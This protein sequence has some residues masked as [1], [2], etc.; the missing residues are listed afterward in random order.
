MSRFLHNDRQGY[1]SESDTWFGFETAEQA[2]AWLNEDRAGIVP[3]HDQGA[4]DARVTHTV[5]VAPAFNAWM[6]PLT[7]P[8]GVTV[9][10]VVNICE[11]DQ[12]RLRSLLTVV[13]TSG[14]LTGSYVLVGTREA[15][16]S[17]QGYP[18]VVGQSLE[19]KSTREVWA[20]LAAG[21]A[22]PPIAVQIG[23]MVESTAG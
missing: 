11:G 2:K 4:D 5:S 12:G 15:V 8:A 19:L 20:A 21:T 7:C 3:S 9:G 16:L 23:I 17:G 10:P 6:M 22:T 14:T 13:A 18:L 1:D